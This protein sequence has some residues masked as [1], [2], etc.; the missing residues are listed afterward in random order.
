M[1]PIIGITR[2]SSLDDYVVSV[3]QAG[4]RVRILEVTES[5]K[6]VGGEIHGLLLTGGGDVDPVF[7]R[8]DR[9]P[10]QGARR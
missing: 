6:T 2:C 7:Y 10:A 1:T 4:G 9:H 8:A 3:E 5:P